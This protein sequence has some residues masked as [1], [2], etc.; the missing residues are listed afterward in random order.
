MKSKIRIGM[1]GLL[2]I[3]LLV[4]MAVF[5]SKAEEVTFPTV[6]IEE[7]RTEE[8]GLLN[9]INKTIEPIGLT[10]SEILWDQMIQ[11][12]SG[13]SFEE[14]DNL[15]E[16]QF[17]EAVNGSDPVIMVPVLC[18]DGM[19]WITLAKGPEITDELQKHLSEEELERCIAQVGRWT[20]SAI[21]ERK[22]TQRYYREAIRMI[23]KERD[24]GEAKVHVIAGPLRQAD[25]IALAFTSE[26][27]TYLVP[28]DLVIKTTLMDEKTEALTSDSGQTEKFVISQEAT[29][30]DK[31]VIT[32]DEMKTFLDELERK[33]GPG[34]HFGATWPSKST[35]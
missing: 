31:D 29:D 27:E 2:V 30:I 17:L 4:G 9:E 22:G 3:G 26:G 15:T 25:A 18:K 19:V 10:A 8:D 7:L 34:P 12:Y 13:F 11:A 33:H 16:E 24:I 20:V 1:L 28:F 21:E 6:D 32:F 35:D 5:R 14:H 23:L